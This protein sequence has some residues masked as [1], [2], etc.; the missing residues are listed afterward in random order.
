M[1]LFMDASALVAI[2]NTEAGFERYSDQANEAEILLT[3]AVARWETVRAMTRENKHTIA[4]AGLALQHLLDLF[5]VETV[6]IDDSVAALAIEAHSQ[7]GKGNHDARLNMGDCFAYACA[8]AN[9]AKLL[10][11]GDD[12]ALTD[13]A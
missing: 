13:M 11:Q 6:P 7:Y 8:K 9:D 5:E 12:F 2:L 1:K 4:S 10:Y 3:S